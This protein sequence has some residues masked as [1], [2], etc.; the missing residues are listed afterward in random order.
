MSIARRALLVIVG[1]IFLDVLI[2][3]SLFWTLNQT[4]GRR[5]VVKSW[6]EQSGIYENIVDRIIEEA[7]KEVE[8][9]ESPQS[10]EIDTE[11]LA[12]AAKKTF[13]PVI[14]RDTVET[15]LD[16][17]YNWLEGSAQ[18]LTFTIDFTK[19]KS[20]L[21]DNIVA[22]LQTKF[23]SLRVCSA[24]DLPTNGD[25]DIFAIN[26][27]PPNFEQKLAEFR[28]EFV[29]NED[30]LPDPV[31]A[32]DELKI[33]NAN[34]K[35]QT[36][37]QAYTSLPER[38]QQAKK[39]LWASTVLAILLLPVVIL[40]SKT[41]RAGLKHVAGMLLGAGLLVLGFGIAFNMST[42]IIKFGEDSLQQTVA[43]PL[44]R[45]I[46]SSTAA[47]MFTVATIYI[48]LAAAIFGYVFFTRQKNIKA[49]ETTNEL[50]GQENRDL[51]K[52]TTGEK[53]KSQ[54]KD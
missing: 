6:F 38:Y 48:L 7:K 49:P 20:E 54:S 44:A 50:E 31:I 2:A 1:I 12:Q 16:G 15:V 36:I 30:F 18:Q 41:K 13:T 27:R 22:E 25:V 33:E 43:R 9:T 8:P 29:T 11:L 5:E 19:Q 53:E 17:A 34:G 24:A 39:L 47:V 3:L 46:T 40:L 37:D 35:K 32:A 51:S 45:E 4:I 23:A 21:A 52:D 28:S 14:L 26:C 42:S 10:S